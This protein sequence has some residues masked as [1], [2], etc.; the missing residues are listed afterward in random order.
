MSVQQEKLVIRSSRPNQR[1]GFL[2]VM[3]VLVAI[4]T[5]QIF[6]YGRRMGGFDRFDAADREA[7][8]SREIQELQRLNEDLRAQVALLKT[9]ADIDKQAYSRIEISLS[10]LQQEIQTQQEE[11]AFYQSIVAPADGKSGLRV[12]EFQVDSRGNPNT[13]SLGIVVIRT[14]KHDSRVTGVVD[15]T[16][17]GLQ[18]GKSVSLSLNDLTPSAS[19]VSPLEFKFRYF[20]D[21]ERDIV[22]PSD[23]TPQ[24]VHVELKPKSRWIKSVTQSFDWRVSNS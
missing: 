14:K 24:K 20:Q 6:E 8:L 12:Q 9:S 21:F 18:N 1:W 11:L 22:L 3:A 5:W 17:E 15:L 13:Y 10:G 2:L 23:F 4:A 19:E 7:G 16:V